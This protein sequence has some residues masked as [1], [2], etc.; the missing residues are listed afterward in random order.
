VTGVHL[1]DITLQRRLA[2]RTAVEHVEGSAAQDETHDGLLKFNSPGA[3]D[4]QVSEGLRVNSHVA[5][6]P[7]RGF[8]LWDSVAMNGC[9]R[10]F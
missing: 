9:T 8:P 10:P 1:Y 7:R 3:V 6:K 5:S 4:C 2:L